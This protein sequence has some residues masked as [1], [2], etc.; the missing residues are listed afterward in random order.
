MDV[1]ELMVVT[2]VLGLTTRTKSDDGIS[3]FTAVPLWAVTVIAEA[4]GAKILTFWARKVVRV[5]VLT[6]GM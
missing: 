5:A 2:A 4:I 6:L 3:S 1:V